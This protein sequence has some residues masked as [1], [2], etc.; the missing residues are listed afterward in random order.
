MKYGLPKHKFD[1]MSEKTKQE[2]RSAVREGSFYLH[3]MSD[4]MS[5]VFGEIH[6]P[7][8]KRSIRLHEIELRSMRISNATGADYFEIRGRFLDVMKKLRFIDGV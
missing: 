8:L 6:M 2:I 7:H 5:I 4:G 3:F 1:K